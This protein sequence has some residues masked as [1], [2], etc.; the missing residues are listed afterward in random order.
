LRVWD[1][2]NGAQVFEAWHDNFVTDTLRLGDALLSSSY[3]GQV[4]SHNGTL[5]PATARATR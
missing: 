4:L 3:D 1:A 2:A 5:P